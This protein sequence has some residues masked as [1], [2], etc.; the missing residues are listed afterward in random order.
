M[1]D[2]AATVTDATL[3]SGGEVTDAAATETGGGLADVD[4]C[5]G[6]ASTLLDSGFDCCPNDPSKTQPGQCGCGIP[7]TDTDGDGVADCIDGCP[8]DRTRTTPGPCGCGV[9]DRTPLCLA[10]RYSFLAAGDG[11]A[12]DA[13]SIDASLGDASGDAGVGSVIVDSVGGANGVSVNVQLSGSGGLVLQGG[14]SGQYVSLPSGIV[15]SLGRSA[16]FECWLT[17]TG[18]NP[19]QRIFDFGISDQGAGLPGNGVQY[20]FLTPLNGITNTLRTAFTL[21]GIPGE[22]QVSS[23]AAFPTAL[24]LETAVVVDGVASTIALYENGV[25]LGQTT[26][27]ASAFAGGLLSSL[28]DANNWLGRSQFAAD[29]AFAGTLREFRMYSAARTTA[30]ILASAAAGPSALPAQ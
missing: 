24:M 11:G 29:A 2:A 17:W 23:S 8:K 5:L 3:D 20:F 12:G 22:T 10:H 30:Q 19:W 9:A 13:G 7:D 15:S 1:T 21:T 4:L 6:D 16:T 28:E 25:P 18:G 26:L 14:N 27:P